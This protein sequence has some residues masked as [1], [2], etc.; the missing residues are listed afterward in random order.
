MEALTLQHLAARSCVLA[1][2]LTVGCAGPLTRGSAF[3]GSA[4][5]TLAVEFDH[6][7]PAHE[8]L[9]ALV[10][11]FEVDCLWW[12]TPGAAPLLSRGVLHAYW[13]VT[14]GAVVGE[15]AGDLLG[16][17]FPCQTRTGWDA[18]RG[19]Y[20]SDWWDGAGHLLLP[21]CDGYARSEGEFV[22]TRGSAAASAVQV[23]TVLGNHEHRIELSARAGAPGSTPHPLLRLSCR[24]LDILE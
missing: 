2:C 24:R 4:P 14:A 12:P 11:E 9:L 19:C 13:D 18:V 6:P 17:F 21:L 20:V 8:T 16:G 3:S 23:L 1:A 22:F 7:R 5:L 15:F 10:G